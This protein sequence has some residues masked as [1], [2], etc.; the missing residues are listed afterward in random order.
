MD[1]DKKNPNIYSDSYIINLGYVILEQLARLVV[2]LLGIGV[3]MGD[4]E[5][6]DVGEC[7]VPERFIYFAQPIHGDHAL[8]DVHQFAP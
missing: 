8:N 4:A 1:P 5:H 3:G 2:Q 6:V 7:V